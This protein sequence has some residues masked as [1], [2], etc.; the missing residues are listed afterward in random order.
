METRRGSPALAPPLISRS[1]GARELSDASCRSSASA[2]CPELPARLCLPLPSVR[3]GLAVSL[4]RPWLVAE[5]HLARW[6]CV[7]REDPLSGVAGWRV[8]F[9]RPLL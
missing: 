4:P 3:F 8:A 2:S 1:L 5:R 6:V 7:H 9:A